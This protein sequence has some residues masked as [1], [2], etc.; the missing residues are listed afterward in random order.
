MKKI[1]FVT[2][3]LSLFAATFFVGCSSIVES[4]EWDISPVVVRIYIQNDNGDNL[5]DDSY[6]GNILEYIVKMTYEGEEYN[7]GE[8][9]VASRAY[10]P[11]FEG[12]QLIDSDSGPYITFGQFEGADSYSMDMSLYLGT[13]IT[14]EISVVREFCW[15]SD[16]EPEG[17]TTYY[18]DG[19]VV[20]GNSIVITSTDKYDDIIWDYA[21]VSLCITVSDQDGQDLLDES[22]EGN[23]LSDGI[24][25]SYDGSNYTMVQDPSQVQTRAVYVEFY[26]LTRYYSDYDERYLLNFGDFEGNNSYDMTLQLNLGDETQYDLRYVRQFDHANLLE[27]PIVEQEFYIN[28]EKIDSDIYEIVL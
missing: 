13:G 24:S 6:E 1:N 4:M 14:S 10:L 21:P 18:L 27:Q 7:L 23:I 9:V 19:E 17:T 11:T 8:E 16:G 15:N 22:V 26:G 12:L 28:G 3:L 25:L 20:D 2:Q 5:L